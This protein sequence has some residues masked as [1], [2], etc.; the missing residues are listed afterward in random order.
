M[1]RPPWYWRLLVTPLT[2]THDVC[3]VWKR[4]KT[5]NQLR[6][7]THCE[8]LSSSPGIW[9][10]RGFSA[11]VAVLPT[12]PP[13]DQCFLLSE[14]LDSRPPPNRLVS[15]L[16]HAKNLILNASLRR[17]SKSAATQAYPAN[18]ENGVNGTAVLRRRPGYL[19][20]PDI[21]RLELVRV[22]ERWVTDRHHRTL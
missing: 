4:N 21:I 12:F 17:Q 20:V 18:Y 19:R 16:T 13:R 7:P 8:C 9:W 15:K 3:S 1:C 14:Q 11:P 22:L 5:N 6:T 10:G 2:P